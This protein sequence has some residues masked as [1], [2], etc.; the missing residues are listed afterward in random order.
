MR[1]PIWRLWKKVTSRWNL[2]QPTEVKDARDTYEM[3]GRILRA[4]THELQWRLPGYSNVQLGPIPPTRY[5]VAVEALGAGSIVAIT[6]GLPV[7]VLVASIVSAGFATNTIAI[8]NA[9]TCGTYFY[10]P[11]L[12]NSSN[13]VEFKHRVEV[14]SGLYAEE[15]YGASS[16]I[17]NCNKF[18]NQSITYSLDNRASCPFD[19]NVC[20]GM[21]DSMMFTT[22][23]V[24][25][26]A[27]GV[28]TANPLL[29][30]R[31]MACSPL[32]TGPEYVSIGISDLGEEQWE[33][34]YGRSLAEY[35]WTNPVTESS[36]EIKGY[37]TG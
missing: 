22:G 12:K 28:N 6:L 3:T 18:Y 8:S 33:Y 19:G 4:M 31:T 25:A 21:N 37:S 17:E 9:E 29:F 2:L 1:I 11:G 10:K 26:S 15:C 36:W 20:H 32:V 23:L 27:L 35:T 34:W 7:S 30:S 5:S 14:E 24:P 13:F 16:L